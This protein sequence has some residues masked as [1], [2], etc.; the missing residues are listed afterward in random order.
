M[1]HSF[2]SCAR[3][4][5]SRPVR[6][7]RNSSQ[8]CIAEY[9]EERTML[10]AQ[11]L[12]P[13]LDAAAAGNQTDIQTT[14]STAFELDVHYSTTDPAATEVQTFGMRML[15]DSSEVTFDGIK[16]DTLLEQS[17]IFPADPTNLASFVFPD[18]DDL[19]G[20][21]DTDMYAQFT[22][23]DANGA[24]PTDGAALLFTAMFTTTA[25]FSG[26][27]VNLNDALLQEG[28]TFSSTP[29][30]INAVG[31]TQVLTPDANFA[32]AGNQPEVSA[33]E[34]STFT[35][36]VNYST[37]NPVD[38]KVQTLGMRMFFDDTQVNFTGF[39]T[40][41]LLDTNRIFPADGTNL[42]SF[43]FDD[44]MDLDNDAS[45]T[46]YAQLTWNDANA[47]WPPGAEPAT[48]FRANFETL[49]GFAGTTINLE[50][51]L[52]QEGFQFSSTPLAVN[53]QTGPI[54]TTDIDGNGAFDALTDGILVIR[55]LSNFSGDVLI[56]D[57]VAA[58][59][60]RASVA[61]ITD[62]LD[63][64]RPVFLDV[65]SNTMQDALTDGIL[66]IRHLAG[67]EGNQ[68]VDQAIGTGATRTAPADITAFLNGF[69]MLPGGLPPFSG[70]AHSA[71][72]MDIVG[73]EIPSVV[74]EP[75]V[76]VTDASPAADVELSDNPA[77]L[78]ELFFANI[79]RK[80]EA[81]SLDDMF[82]AFAL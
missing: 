81:E 29:A 60:T 41:T 51:A 11:V 49:A 59:A 79:V 35:F 16:T 62:F 61:D 68:L 13:D 47:Q 76:R 57:A 82:L 74:T 43:V 30:E 27:T 55:Y 48:L 33:A 14:P 3:L 22:W 26:T 71:P 66:F 23:N 52:L 54:I 50:D 18:T 65:D 37:E 73:S 45:T 17:R 42:A 46:K 24:W 53:L 63:A 80:D 21:A 9:L 19:D 5:K 56:R 72:A 40:D 4:K 1:F 44:T 25:G 39:E 67:F 69:S 15:F 6:R 70:A 2:R 38:Q 31:P 32:L 12:T 77:T 58:D 75:D 10:T 64:A 28:F 7:Q 36:D 34:S 20:D 8:A 78:H